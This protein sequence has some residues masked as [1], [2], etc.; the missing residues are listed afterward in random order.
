DDEQ[1]DV[2]EGVLDRVTLDR[3]GQRER[4]R[5]VA[6]VDVE[7]LGHPAVA[8]RGGELARGQRDVARLLAVAV[9]HGRHLA[10][11]AGTAGTTLAELGAWLGAD[12]YLGHGS[13]PVV[14]LVGGAGRR[15]VPGTSPEHRVDH[16][17]GRRQPPEHPRRA[18]APAYPSACAALAAPRPRRDR[19]T[20]SSPSR[21]RRPRGW[22][23]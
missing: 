10:G 18:T 16:G 13:T 6:D 12:L 15:C 20:V 1:V 7:D 14:I 4:G 5:P 21:R 22:P 19:R 9:Q 23:A 8:D 2:V 17:T 11:P 3:L